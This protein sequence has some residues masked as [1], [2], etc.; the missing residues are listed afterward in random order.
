[1]KSLLPALFMVA[2]LCL[3]SVPATAATRDP[4]PIVMDDDTD[5]MATDGRSLIGLF[6]FVKPAR[7]V[8]E[9]GVCR[10]GPTV[11]SS[12]APASS[13]ACGESC[14]CGSQRVAAKTEVRP[15]LKRI[16]S[17]YPG[18]VIQSLFAR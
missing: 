2:T 18:K 17:W 9:N 5:A 6:D 4:A 3:L 12:P 7:T 11:A 14:P 1:M 15:L 13:C 10:T 16:R 8:C